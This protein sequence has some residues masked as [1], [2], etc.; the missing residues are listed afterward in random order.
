MDMRHVRLAVDAFGDYGVIASRYEGSAE[1]LIVAL[2]DDPT[3]VRT[4][5][6][7]AS[8]L[9][10]LVN[11]GAIELVG[12]EGAFG[13]VD[14]AWLAKFPD[15]ELRLAMCESLLEVL[16]LSPAEYCHIFARTPFYLT[17]LEDKDVY[18]ESMR[19]WDEIAPLRE[20]IGGFGPSGPTIG[21]LGGAPPELCDL[22]PEVV[23]YGRVLARRAETMVFNLQSKM[24]E[25]GLEAA[26]IVASAPVLDL[27][28]DSLRE[29]DIS[30]VWI[31]AGGGD[32]DL[33][34]CERMLLDRVQGDAD[35]P[36]DA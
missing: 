10:G 24:G 25:T 31:D 4:R 22:Y 26:A 32:G 27:M 11:V 29:Q 20:N 3:T 6:R 34:T 9:G 1:G 16:S 17:G 23:D 21:E 5:R 14:T 12:V 8:I 18:R 13:D 36:A 15:D 7:L 35:A 2:E 19:L 30:Y 33:R 28:S